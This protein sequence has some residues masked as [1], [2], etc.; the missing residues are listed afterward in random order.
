V[1][2]ASGRYNG[3][4]FYGNSYWMGSMSFCNEI[5]ETTNS[6]IGARYSVLNV[7]IDEFHSANVVS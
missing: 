3:K 5:H 2:D 7:L 4:F 6:P 1:D